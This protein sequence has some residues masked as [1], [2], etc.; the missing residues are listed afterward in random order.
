MSF[1][2][3]APFITLDPVWKTIPFSFEYIL[4]HKDSFQMG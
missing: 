4:K 2:I 3:S 1:W